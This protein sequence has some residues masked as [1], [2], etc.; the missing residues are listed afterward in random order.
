L[1]IASRPVTQQQLSNWLC[2]ENPHS[3]TINALESL[4]RR[5]LLQ[6]VDPSDIVVMER[7]TDDLEIT[8]QNHYTL[9][10][11]VRKY[12]SNRFIQEFCQ[13]MNDLIATQRLSQSGL[14]S[15]HHLVQSESPEEFQI[16]QRHLFLERI[17]ANLAR[18]WVSQDVLKVNCQAILELF[19]KS[20]IMIKGYGSDNLALLMD[21]IAE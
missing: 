21:V 20:T 10:P 16:I 11:V 18:Q 19:A 12:I 7:S 14:V 15:S 9:E 6:V 3:S 4:R 5:S 17:V 1:A 13:N 2:A 8:S